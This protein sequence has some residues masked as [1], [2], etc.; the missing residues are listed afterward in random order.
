[1]SDDVVRQR[2]KSD[3]SLHTEESFNTVGETL[4]LNLSE[5]GESVLN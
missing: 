5:W 3:L 2:L 1:V 4:H